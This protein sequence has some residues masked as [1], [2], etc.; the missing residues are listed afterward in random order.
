[1]IT[2][3]LKTERLI[4]R[5]VSLQDLKDLFDICSNPNVTK[6]MSWDTHTSNEITKSYIQYLM[7][8]YEQGESL[9]WVIEFKKEQ[10]VIGM[11]SYIDWADIDKSAELGFNRMEG[12]CNDD[13]HQSESVMQKLGMIYEDTLRKKRWLK[14]A[15]RNTKVYSKLR[16]EFC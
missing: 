7:N 15:Y 6:H 1:M 16:E 14:G 11:C 3:L 13:N 8:G 12:R 9:D 4:L 5:Q 10:K 2:K